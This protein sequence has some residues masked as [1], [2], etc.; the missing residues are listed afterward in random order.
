MSKI[1]LDDL[2]RSW[3]SGGEDRDEDS[4]PDRETVDERVAKARKEKG[5]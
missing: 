4:D 5:E 2:Y 1:P 3:L